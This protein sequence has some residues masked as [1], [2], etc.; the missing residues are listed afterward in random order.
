MTARQRS[1]MT[2]FFLMVVVYFEGVESQSC[3][4]L[5]GATKKCACT[6]QDGSTSK[7]MDFTPLANA[8]GQGPAFPYKEVP[9]E[10]YKYAY[11][12]CF[13]FSDNFCQ[14]AAA[15]QVSK[16][17]EHIYP[18]GDPSSVSYT[19]ENSDIVITYAGV[20]GRSAIVNFHCDATALTQA[21]YTPL[22]E[23][24]TD[25]KFTV[26]TCLACLTDI[27]NCH[28][29]SPPGGGDSFI[30]GALCITF[31][32][33]VVVYIVGGILFQKFHRGATGKE[34]IPNYA[35]WTDFPI[36]VKDGFMFL[37]GLCRGGSSG[38]DYES[39]K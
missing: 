4:N 20:G 23:Q 11:N 14:D 12:P 33:L 39:I 9:S 29:I 36:L 10:D 32:V 31:T 21:T 25:Y 35:F 22:G 37:I 1:F 3:E 6:Y 13:P 7:Y 17:E 19:V 8:A 2:L 38:S 26:G 5:V 27:P 15:C 28:S 24:G 30:G 18:I 16:D 34:L